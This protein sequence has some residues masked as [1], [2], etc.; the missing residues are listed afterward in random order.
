MKKLFALAIL[1]STT[2][3]SAQEVIVDKKF[4]KENVPLGYNFIPLTEEIA[5]QEG[6]P[7]GMFVNRQVTKVTTFKPNKE[8][9]LWFDNELLMNISFNYS[10]KVLVAEEHEKMKWVGDNS[11]V[12]YADGV[13]VFDKKT[14]G[15]Y[16]YDD[17][18]ISYSGKEA[19]ASI[20][21][22]KDK[23]SNKYNIKLEGLFERILNNNSY[24]SQ[25]APGLKQ[26]INENGETEVVSK[27]I[28]K[29]CKSSTIYRTIFDR[30]GN[31][32]KETSYELNLDGYSFILSV[33]NGGYMATKSVGGYN[34]AAGANNPA[35]F[36]GSV[37]FS[38][39]SYEDFVDDGS[40]N[41]MLFDNDGNVFVYGMM[42]KKDKEN[43][44]IN[45]IMGY[46]IFKFDKLG[47]LIWKKLIETDK[48]KDIGGAYLNNTYVRLFNQDNKIQFLFASSKPDEVVMFSEFN[49]DG[50]FINSDFY[51]FKPDY[52]YDIKGFLIATITDKKLLSN[53]ILDFEGLMLYYKNQKIK[54]YI[55]SVNSKNKIYFNTIISKNL[56]WL[57]ESD[58][59]T[60]YKVLRF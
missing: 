5:I 31:K 36:S 24:K 13:A 55:D 20:V 38:S 3:L 25:R 2:F 16:F 39:R 14:I 51:E 30:T 50:S 58:N 9:K 1:T 17:A 11:K 33:T 35:G 47:K 53:K 52:T 6:K 60:Y 56:T 37:G 27:F 28:P 23:K 54:S 41:N 12:F 4:E 42:G 29:D 21:Y 10:G 49:S 45:K 43:I 26:Y 32:I 34:P 46:Y 22:Y 18:L 7:V 8:S 48:F 40:I 15:S 57:I 44:L 59:K 19:E